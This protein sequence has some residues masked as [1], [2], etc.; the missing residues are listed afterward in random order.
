MTVAAHRSPDV[1]LRARAVAGLTRL[2]PLASGAGSLGNHRLLRRLSGD[3]SGIA[4]A[5]LSG[6]ERLHVRLDDYVGRAAFF[7]GDL[8]PKV[9]WLCRR[10]LRAGDLAIDAGANQGVITVRMAS[11]VGPTG[12]VLAFEPNPP[13]VDLL[14]QSIAQAALSQVTLHPIALGEQEAELELTVPD[15]NSGKASLAG[16]HLRGRHVRVPVRRL[17]DVLRD[18]PGPIRLL[19][20]DVEGFEAPLLRGASRMLHDRPPAVIVFECNDHAAPIGQQAVPRLLDEAGYAI[21]SL[22]FAWV[23][24]AIVPVDLGRPPDGHEL[25]AVHRSAEHDTIVRRLR[26]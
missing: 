10:V 6:G 5:R 18:V 26:L 21:Y 9:T 22:P 13:L 12:R 25:V 24:P 8:D 4:V 17:D 20:L 7:A 15:D 16:S 14:R 1:S 3:P 2:F 23:R 11:S 19:K